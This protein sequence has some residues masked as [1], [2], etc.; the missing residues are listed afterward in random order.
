MTYMADGK[1]YIVMATQ[2]GHM[3]AYSLPSR[4]TAYNRPFAGP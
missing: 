3:V 4:M 1:Q 2:D